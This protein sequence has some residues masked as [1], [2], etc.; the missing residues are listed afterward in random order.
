MFYSEMLHGRRPYPAPS[1]EYLDWA[2]DIETLRVTLLSRGLIFALAH[3][4]SQQRR[5]SFKNI[6]SICRMW[7]R[8]VQTVE[9]CSSMSGS[10]F[11]LT[12][13]AFASLYT[14]ALTQSIA[15]N[16]FSKYAKTY[17]EVELGQGRYVMTA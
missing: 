7:S 8:T 3:A 10:F 17:R 15:H 6:C 11:L 9:T 1:S 13:T 14:T 16:E 4:V 2:W 12:H 5:Q